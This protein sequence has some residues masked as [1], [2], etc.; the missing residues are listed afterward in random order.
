MSNIDKRALRDMAVTAD[1]PYRPDW[2]SKPSTRQQ[3]KHTRAQYFQM[4]TRRANKFP[5]GL[6]AI[7]MIELGWEFIEV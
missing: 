5:R 4:D 7:R 3:T 1:Y 2:V 6:C